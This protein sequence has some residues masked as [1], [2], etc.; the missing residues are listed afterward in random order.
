MAIIRVN[1]TDQ[2][3]AWLTKTNLLSTGVG[4]IQDLPVQ[5]S[6][7]VD[8][9]NRLSSTLSTINA[10]YRDSAEIVDISRNATSV[11]D[12]GGLGSLGYAANTGAITYT[13]P[14]FYDV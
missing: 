10:E 8:A 2:V 6:N 13:G 5:D 12:N 1:L 3:S 4:D 7:V 11:V 14:S 9:I